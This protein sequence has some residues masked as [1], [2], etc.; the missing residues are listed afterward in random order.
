MEVKGYEVVEKAVRAFWELAYPQDVIVFFWQKYDNDK[1][2]EWH[3]ELVEFNGY[4][5]DCVMTFQNDFYEGQDCVHIVDVIP[6]DAVKAYYTAH[7][8]NKQPPPAEA[9]GEMRRE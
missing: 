3:E 7:A 8:I 1:E 4:Y 2:W 6:F 9:E 5:S